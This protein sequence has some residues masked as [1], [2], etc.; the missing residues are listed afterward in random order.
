MWLRHWGLARDPFSG[1]PTPY[2]PLPSHDEARARLVFSIERFHP[3]I[4]LCAEAGMGKTAVV[5]Q[6]LREVRNP[7]RRTVLVDAPMEG[8]D[9]LGRLADGL[10]LPSAAG[11]DREGVWRSLVRRLRAEAIEGYHVVLVVDHWD[12][13]P[14][15]VTMQDL[16]ALG[17]VAGPKGPPLSL[18]RVGRATIDGPQ[19]ACGSCTLAIGLERLTR[20]ES[21]IYIGAKLADAGCHDRVFTPRALSRLHSWA[22]GV[23]GA[24]GELAAY[25]MLAGA[26]QG[27]EVV[28]PETVD[29]V[30]LRGYVGIDPSLTAR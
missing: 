12:S 24:L 11:S 27:L 20:S 22:E 26:E 18:I 19:G 14:G 15:P 2:V 28:T 30:A 4:N 6:A 17:A 5:R 25:A 16:R 23:P 3:L 10:G 29:A 7:R 13:D 8:H 9:L 21:D 1:M